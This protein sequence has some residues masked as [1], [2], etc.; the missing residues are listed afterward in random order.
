MKPHIGKGVLFSKIDIKNAFHQ[1][2]LAPDSREITTFITKSGLFR[3]KRLMFGLSCAPEI[4]QKVMEHILSGIPGCY[5]YIDDIIIIGS[6][7]EEHDKILSRVLK[8]LKEYQVEL[9]MGKCVFR[10]TKLVFLGHELSTSGIRPTNDKLQ[11]VKQF[12]QPKNKDEV[13]SF[14]GLINYV[15]KFIPNVA[16]ETE[17]LRVLARYDSK[18]HWGREQQHAFNELKEKL[19]NESIL[20]Y[21]DPIDKTQWIADASSVGLGSVLVQIND[22]G[23][24]IIEWES[25]SLTETEKRYCQTEKEALALVWAVERHHF[26]VYGRVFDLITDHRAL[27]VIFGPKSRPCARIER[28]VLR[29]QSYKYNIIY[30]PGR[31]NIADPFSRLCDALKSMIISNRH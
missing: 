22:D 31:S 23:I 29:L 14:L 9:N 2:E 27:E 6:T 5:N 13:K 30:K 28:W 17:A 3:Y 4:F 10:V 16:T 8:R 25:R 18:F 11:A 26:Y 19:S 15:S 24:R 21:Y 1:L 7:D 20:G 12:R